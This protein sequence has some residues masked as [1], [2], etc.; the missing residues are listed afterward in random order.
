MKSIDESKP[1]RK[2]KT[3][4]AVKTRYNAKTYYQFGLRLRK[5]EDAE[6][7]EKLNSVPSK[8]DYIKKLIQQDIEK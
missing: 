4:N 8:N 1:R 3:S 5:I 7:I 2:T 6:L